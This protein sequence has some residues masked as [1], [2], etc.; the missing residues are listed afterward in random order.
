ME[1]NT[2]DANS[3]MDFNEYQFRT[4]LTASYPQ[5][6]AI[7]YLVL[8]LT[9]EAGEVAGKYKKII[10]DNDGII[11]QES[12]LALADEVGDVLWYCSELAKHLN[13]NLGAIAIRNAEKLQSRKTRGV[14][15]GSG[16]NR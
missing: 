13:M 3:L 6:R 9:S 12:M 14:I 5:A 2:Y 10:R 16:D 11:T 1:D 4:G 15:G 8:G 7:E